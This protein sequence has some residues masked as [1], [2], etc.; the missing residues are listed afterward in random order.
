MK[1]ITRHTGILTVTGRLPNSA[2][3]NPRYMFTIDGYSARTAVDSS[4]CYSITNYDGKQVT[5]TLGSHYGVLTLN[6]IHKAGV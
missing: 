6:S 1:N 3:G 4:H 5:A 2:N